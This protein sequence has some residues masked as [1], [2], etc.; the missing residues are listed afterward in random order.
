MTSGS[1]SP[2]Y[3]S[4]PHELVATGSMPSS[5]P[6]HAAPSP[7]QENDE[8]RSR[9]L[10][11][12]H[13]LY[14]KSPGQLSRQ[15]PRRRLLRRRRRGVLHRPG[16]A[17]L[18]GRGIDP[19]DGPVVAGR[20]DGVWPDGDAER[21]PA[22]V[23]R[24]R[25]SP[26]R[27][28]ARREAPLLLRRPRPRASPKPVATSTY[29]PPRLDGRDRPH[30]GGRQSLELAAEHPERA[31]PVVHRPPGRRSR[32]GGA[33]RWS[34]RCA[35]SP[36]SSPPRRRS[37]PRRASRRP[38]RTSNAVDSPAF[39][40]VQLVSTRS[41]LG[42]TRKTWPSVVPTQ[43]ESNAATMFRGVPPTENVDASAAGSARRSA[44]SSLRRRS[45]SAP[46]PSRPRRRPRSACCRRR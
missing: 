11:G 8:R 12:A 9:L 20:P 14:P 25:R 21:A 27:R 7:R 35:R 23:V 36:A 16:R 30:R 28:G 39:G 4:E 17:H 32:A 37:A 2:S 13:D 44:R 3:R 1:P 29:P 43:S 15:T 22:D 6:A 26:P 24:A 42:S 10:H 31:E 41:V 33:A 40:S 45:S 5:P 18:V 46:T 19:G 34:D 38:G